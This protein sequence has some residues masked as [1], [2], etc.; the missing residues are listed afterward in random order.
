MKK[1]VVLGAALG[2]M[3]TFASYDSQALPTFGGS[4]LLQPSELM[5]VL[6]GCGLGFY[7]SPAGGCV[8]NYN[9]A[10]QRCFWRYGRRI[11]RW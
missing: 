11:C 4:K 5:T 2:L 7:R 1:T 3:I 9:S 6:G 10:Q 8:P